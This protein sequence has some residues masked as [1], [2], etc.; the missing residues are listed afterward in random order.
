M[1]L[2]NSWLKAKTGCR[3]ATILRERGQGFEIINPPWLRA[4]GDPTLGCSSRQPI[5]SPVEVHAGQFPLPSFTLTYLMPSPE[6]LSIPPGLTISFF[7]SLFL[8]D[9]ALLTYLSRY[10]RTKKRLLFSKP[11]RVLY[12]GKSYFLVFS[13]ISFQKSSILILV[14]FWDPE[15]HYAQVGWHPALGTLWNNDNVLI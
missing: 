14:L 7:H 11:T 6:L 15:V 1:L 3:E 10:F 12:G 4:Q 8:K 2:Y 13:R 9:S 5:L